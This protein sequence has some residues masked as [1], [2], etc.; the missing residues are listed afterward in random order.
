MVQVQR[1]GVK[2]EDPLLTLILHLRWASEWGS[3]CTSVQSHLHTEVHSPSRK[4]NYSTVDMHFLKK[5]QP[6]NTIN[7]K[8]S[9]ASFGLAPSPREQAFPVSSL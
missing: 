9:P 5:G 8:D 3:M 7:D 4:T 6:Q 1:P 2:T